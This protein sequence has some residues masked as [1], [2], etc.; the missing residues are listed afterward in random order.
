MNVL[1]VEDYS[2]DAELL[3][4]A[5]RRRA[6]DIR[7]DI[8]SSVAEAT[9]RLNQFEAAYGERARVRPEDRSS[10]EQIDG[11]PRY[12]LVLTDLNLPDGSGLNILSHVR[13][14]RL[15]LAVVILTGFGEEESVI[16]ALHA[17]A[18]DYVTKRGD[19][20]STLPRTLQAA[21]DHFDAEVGR[22]SRPL[23]VPYGEPGT[24]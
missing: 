16:T 13:Q 7:L 8:V 2:I 5:L 12:D 9:A 14:H 10:S 3:Q 6:P 4:D 15:R 19:Y 23:P 1:Y 22:T 11:V 21:L 18:N 20:L 17:G 24:A